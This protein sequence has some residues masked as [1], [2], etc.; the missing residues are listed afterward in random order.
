MYVDMIYV[1]I[2]YEMNNENVESN[3]YIID[4]LTKIKDVEKYDI[5]KTI[6]NQI[7]ILS[8]ILIDRKYNINT[9]ISIT[10]GEYKK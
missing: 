6:Y 8:L 3:K 2:H 9:K 4:K 10:L 1:P 5:R 7:N